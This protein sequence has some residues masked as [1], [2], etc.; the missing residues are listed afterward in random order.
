MGFTARECRVLLILVQ[1]IDDVGVAPVSVTDERLANL[2]RRLE[3]DSKG[4]ILVRSRD[5]TRGSSLLTKLESAIR[6]YALEYYKAQ[7]KR[8]KRYKKALNKSA[9][10]QA[11]YVRHC[12]KIA[13]YYEFRRYTTKVL[14]HYEA[15]YRAIVALPLNEPN[16]K[17]SEVVDF[18]QVKTM[19]EFVNF[20]LCYHLIFSAN[21]VRGA[22]EQ[23]HRHVK[24]YASAIGPP[25]RAYEHWEWLSRQYHVFGQ[26][27]AE[28]V[29]I[30]GSL[31]VPGLDSDVYKEPYLYLSIA[32][33]YATYRRKAAAKL[34]LTASTYSKAALNG[35]ILTEKD[36]V[37]VP[38]VFVGGD[39]VVAEAS[40]PSQ[41]PS[42]QALTKYRHAVERS[43]PHAKRTMHLLEQSIQ[44]LSIYIADQKT[45]RPRLKSRLLVQLGTERL[46]AGEYERA[47]AELQ[48]AKMI[49]TV[50]RWWGQTSQI[51][52]QLLICTFRQGDTAA[53]IDYSL[54]LLSPTVEEFVPAN[55]R[56]R[57]Q[58][59]MML[60]WRDPSRLGTPFTPTSALGDGHEL[61]LDQCRSLIALTARFDCVY[62]C[63]REQA[64]LELRLESFFPSPITMAKIELKFSDDRYNCV[65]QH[66]ST[67][68]QNHLQAAA[69]GGKLSSRLEFAYKTPVE[70]VVPLRVLE[71]REVL[72]FQEVKLYLSNSGGEA[73]TGEEEYLIFNLLVDQLVP[74]VRET[75][76]PYLSEGRVP[77]M[78]NG[79]ASPSFARRKTMFSLS[80]LSRTTSDLSL[81]GLDS[82]DIGDDELPVRGPTLVILQP[83]PK[84]KLSMITRETLITG[85]YRV[86]AFKLSSNE[87]TLENLSFHVRCE[88]PPVSAAPEDAF[89]FTQ[90]EPG[91]PLSPLPLDAAMQP[92]DGVALSS[93]EQF[94]DRRL[95][96][97]VRPAHASQ[98][99]LTVSVAYATKS[100][101]AVSFEERYELQCKNPFTVEGGFIHDFPNGSGKSQV[102]QSKDSYAYIGKMVTLQGAVVCASSE[103]LKVL[104]VDFESIE[105]NLVGELQ[106]SGFGVVSVDSESEN[107]ANGGNASSDHTGA[108]V[109]SGDSRSFSLRMCPRLQAP[110]ATLGRVKVTWRRL[111]S[112]ITSTPGQP[113][114]DVVTT[115]LELPTVSFMEA[116]LTFQIRTPPFGV[117]GALVTLDLHV[118]NN[119]DAFHNLRIKPVDETGDFLIAGRTNGVLELLPLDEEVIRI[120]LIPTKS[121][122]SWVL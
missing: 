48:K 103:P 7:A 8:V 47:R 85:D 76:R 19:A 80:E 13:H 90:Q 78:G 3:T 18:N 57:I 12:F 42:P 82:S 55:E 84:A 88:P 87:D 56:V 5:I 31:S 119:E 105:R 9:A 112:I 6:N 74:I 20:K 41:E 11:L 10:H 93:L 15:A 30:R 106:P 62:A 92:R 108:I 98:V 121:G 100:G 73:S 96:V 97:I 37:V 104:A 61:A 68:E 69:D 2:R 14:Q 16:D 77:A 22:I 35:E 71:G 91:G 66:D 50:E 26:L 118:K 113:R 83:R 86:L 24:T 27:L 49:F 95:N 115:W 94:T 79:S 21:N 59:S 60:A 110:F 72:R 46:A 116:P 75:V 65:V 122:T 39:P 25:N 99:R 36:F 1:Q 117:E 67:S 107:T 64:N 114:N 63:V 38:S 52:K 51:L 4:L 43:V 40:S 28:A 45:P 89:F 81:A 32:A 70:L 23:L 29:S 54:Q 33:K 58:D 101:V 109:R 111:S 53:Y 17:S 102:A 120:G 44:H 34:G